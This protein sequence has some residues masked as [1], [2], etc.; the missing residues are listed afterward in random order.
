MSMR[1]LIKLI[2]KSKKTPKC[3]IKQLKDF[4]TSIRQISR[5]TGVSFGIIRNIQ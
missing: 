1:M 2:E 3:I 4:G 5:L